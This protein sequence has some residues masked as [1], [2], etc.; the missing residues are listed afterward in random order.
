[1]VHTGTWAVLL[2]ALTSA[3]AQEYF[4]DR[5]VKRQAKDVLH[6]KSLHD[7]EGRKISE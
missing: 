5:K 1:M 4:E 3:L 2:L 6:S 7:G